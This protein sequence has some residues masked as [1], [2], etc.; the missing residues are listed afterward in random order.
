[1]KY[2][3]L[4]TYWSNISRISKSYAFDPILMAAF[5]AQ[6]SGGIPQ[7][8]RFEPAWHFYNDPEKYARLLGISVETEKQLQCFS[9][10]LMQI[11]G[12]SAR[13]M[14]YAGFLGQLC[15]PDIGLSV[16]CKFLDEKRKKYHDLKDMISSYNMGTPRKTPA[17]LYVNQ[18]YVDGVI[19]HANEL[20]GE[21]FALT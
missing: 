15:D 2:A 12:A 21:S 7:R 14:G 5:I 16:A 11:M 19:I 3:W 20:R 8:T 10:G 9:Y 1:M 18:A 6:E 13:D 17:G 4:P